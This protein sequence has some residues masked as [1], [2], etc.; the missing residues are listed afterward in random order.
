MTGVCT[1]VGRGPEA[2]NGLQQ[3][4]GGL[5]ACDPASSS[6]KRR[7]CGRKRHNVEFMASPERRTA[8]EMPRVLEQG[9]CH[10]QWKIIRC[11]KN[12]F[13]ALL[14]L[15]RA[16]AP[17]GL[18][19]DGL[20][21]TPCEDKEPSSGTRGAAQVHD[22]YLVLCPQRERYRRLASK[23]CKEEQPCLYHSQ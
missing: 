13:H 9:H 1:S 10:L 22:C 7:I 15:G 21:M 16:G 6:I 2:G 18:V 8:T 14:G 3:P 11:L 19:R 23:G 17:Y 4:P 20:R 12:S 5:R